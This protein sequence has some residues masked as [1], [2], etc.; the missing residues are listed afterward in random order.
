MSTAKEKI[1]DSIG[2]FI[3]TDV[4]PNSKEPIESMYM[5]WRNKTNLI[6]R[7]P[8]NA[9]YALRKFAELGNMTEREREAFAET[10]TYERNYLKRQFEECRGR[11]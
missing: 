10:V 4:P 3:L 1:A 5:R 6:I 7:H 8:E 2:C 11:S 9:R